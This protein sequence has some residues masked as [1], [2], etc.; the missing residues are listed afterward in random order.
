MRRYTIRLL[1]FLFL[2]TALSYS[3]WLPFLGNYLVSASQPEPA[4]TIIVLAGDF[5]G[6]RIETAGDLVRRKFA[7]FALVSGPSAIYAKNEADLAIDYAITQ[8]YPRELFRSVYHHSDSTRDEA[9]AFRQYLLQNNLRKVL[10]VTS[11]FHTRRAGAIFRRTMPEI[12]TRMIAAPTAGF[13]PATW[14][15]SRPARKVFFQEWLKT[16]AD[17]LGI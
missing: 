5:A 1:L 9:L 10:I 12:Q 17:W 7:P 13:D 16:L 3:L 8:G 14:W 4:D 2:A 6:K 11:D 15:Q